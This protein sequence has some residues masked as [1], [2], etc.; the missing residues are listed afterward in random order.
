[1]Q[2]GRLSVE[3][4]VLDHFPEIDPTTVASGWHDVRVKHC[5]SMTVG[6]E[7]DAW[8]MVFD[9]SSGTDYPATEDWVPRV[10][11]TVPTRAPG[12]VFAYNQVATYLLSIIVGACTGQGVAEMLQATAARAARA[13]RH[14][15]APR[16]ARS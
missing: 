12:T 5:L 10:F 14:P 8:E 15:V 16:P 3:D 13:A 6:H 11:A 7:Q 2:E 1:M 9:R 4:R